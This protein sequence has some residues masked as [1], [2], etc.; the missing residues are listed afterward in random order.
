[1]DP[2]S[3]RDYHTKDVLLNAATERDAAVT[4]ED[5]GGFMTSLGVGPQFQR[6]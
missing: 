6:L 1:M 2:R 5:V 4:V 3:S